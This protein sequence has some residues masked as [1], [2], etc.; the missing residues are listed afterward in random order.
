MRPDNFALRTM[1]YRSHMQEFKVETFPPLRP[2][3]SHCVSRTT[4]SS[5]WELGPPATDAPVRGSAHCGGRRVRRRSRAGG[6]HSDVKS[7]TRFVSELSTRSDTC[8]LSSIAL[9]A[10]L[11]IFASLRY[12]VALLWLLGSGLR[13]AMQ[14]PEYQC[15]ALSLLANFDLVQP[16]TGLTKCQ[17]E[18]HA[19]MHGPADA[20]SCHDR[21]RIATLLAIRSPH[22]VFC[23]TAQPSLYCS[24]VGAM[25]LQD[26]CCVL[27]L[28]GVSN[29][30]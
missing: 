28:V 27:L 8:G 11:L 19:S 6:V 7:N 21:R 12:R 4:P 14:A 5:R 25:N 17:A 26:A 29:A 16:R 3:F 13:R 20:F 18:S 24:G 2:V 10:F 30:A 9:L 1:G 22:V 15:R 23:V